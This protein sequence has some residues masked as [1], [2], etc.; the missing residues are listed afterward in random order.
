[1]ICVLSDLGQWG[2]P[3]P[4]YLPGLPRLHV[5]KSSSSHARPVLTDGQ[6]E[7]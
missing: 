4:V 6:D 2:K 1:V 7:E 5:Q 3:H